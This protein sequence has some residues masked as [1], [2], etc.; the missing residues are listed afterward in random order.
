M[1]ATENI[2]V[3]PEKWGLLNKPQQNKEDTM[4]IQ[5]KVQEI[6]KV[7]PKITEEELEKL[8]GQKCSIIR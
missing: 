4:T 8:I 6:I 3:G 1:K 2:N 7:N 5:E